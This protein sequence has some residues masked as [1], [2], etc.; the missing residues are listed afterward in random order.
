MRSTQKNL[1][2][3]TAEQKASILGSVDFF[4][5]NFYTA[6]FVRAPA[7]GAPKSQV[8]ARGVQLKSRSAGARDCEAPR[9]TL[10]T[11]GHTPE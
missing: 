5:L 11:H 2:K 10:K 1:P 3:F 7:A 4:S 9:P 6:H 8:R